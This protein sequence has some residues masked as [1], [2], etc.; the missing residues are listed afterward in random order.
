MATDCFFEGGDMLF[1]HIMRQFFEI[2]LLLPLSLLQFV[3]VILDLTFELVGSVYDLATEPSILD[4]LPF[5]VCKLQS[6]TVVVE[7]FV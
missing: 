7:F 2:H 3:L 6:F 4:I 1:A 5:N